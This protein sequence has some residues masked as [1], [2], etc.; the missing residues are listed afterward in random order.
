MAYMFVSAFR[1]IKT[2]TGASVFIKTIHKIKLYICS[3]IK[4]LWLC[5]QRSSQMQNDGDKR[6]TGDLG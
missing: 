3:D 1:N 2:V 6:F 4:S 5:F